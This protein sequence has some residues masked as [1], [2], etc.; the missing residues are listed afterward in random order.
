MIS[1]IVTIVGRFGVCARLR[2]WGNEQ[3]SRLTEIADNLLLYQRDN[4][5]WIENRDP[6]RILD[7]QW[8]RSTAV[9]SAY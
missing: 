8:R 4:G 2:S 5:A 9:T 3:E 7:V 6:A 1:F